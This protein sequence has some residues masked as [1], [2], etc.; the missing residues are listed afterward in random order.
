[1]IEVQ[2]SLALIQIAAMQGMPQRPGTE[3][4]S[5]PLKG[6]GGL[7]AHLRQMTMDKQRAA[8][9]GRRYGLDEVIRWKPQR[10]CDASSFAFRSGTWRRT[11]EAHG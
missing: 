1:M 10:V 3:E 8:Q 11:G 9:L 6:L 5:E 2:A 7:T 4:E